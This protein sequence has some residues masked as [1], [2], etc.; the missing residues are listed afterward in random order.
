M[1]VKSRSRLRR[2]G[3]ERRGREVMIFASMWARANGGEEMN[4][5]R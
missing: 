2:G 1:R 3:R 5:P 4:L